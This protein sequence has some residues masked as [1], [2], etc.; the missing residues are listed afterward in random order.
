MSGMSNGFEF[1]EG[2]ASENSAAPR[3]TVRRGGVLVL[4]QAAVDMLG[5][6]VTHVQLGFNEKTKAVGIRPA[7]EDTKGRY[8][9]RPQKNGASR[10]IDGKRFFA[11]QGVALETARRFD[12]EAFGD[13]IVGFHLTATNELQT[14]AAEDHEPAKAPAKGT[15]KL[16]K[17]SGGRRRARAA[18]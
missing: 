10:L 6:G 18:A 8:L 4:T 16:A 14:A 7:A 2:I 11:H 13:G 3:V 15:K 17:A 1:F 9:L 12:V 5:D